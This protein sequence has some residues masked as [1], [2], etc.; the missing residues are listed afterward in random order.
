MTEG[1]RNL[2]SRTRKVPPEHPLRK[3]VRKTGL[4]R[5]YK[6]HQHAGLDPSDVFVAAYPKSGS[7][8]VR[9]VL[10]DLVLGRECGF[11]DVESTIRQVGSHREGPE[12]LPG[13]GR[14]IK[15]HE[16][17]R[18]VYRRSI[19]ILRD[20]RDVV[21]SYQRFLV[22]FG[23]DYPDLGA[24]VKLFSRGEV[25][26]YGSWL[27][28]TAG[29]IEARDAGADVHTVLY[30]EIKEAPVRE[31]SDMAR[32]VGL[33]V[34]EDQVAEAVERNTA[35]RMRAKESD[36]GEF[37]SARGWKRT[38]TFVGKARS[39][40]WRER[41]SAD[42]LEALKPFSDLYESIVESRTPRVLS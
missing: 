31:F 36:E 42:D 13:N 12:V 4:R 7:T 23:H 30:D 32:F 17:Y 18:K 35:A 15:T 38:S 14:L 1:A 22:G 19:F 2:E 5:L 33:E 21:L 16:P 25:G 37:F 27:D 34:N 9:F 29:W 28:H 8:W 41:L 3:A 39:G 24:F 10:S 20:P 11:G 40:V 26:G 6:R